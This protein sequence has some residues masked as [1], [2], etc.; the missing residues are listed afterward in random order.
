MLSLESMNE[1]LQALTL[2]VFSKLCR[3]H[4]IVIEDGDLTIILRILKNNPY[5]VFKESYAPIL[6]FE[7]MKETD[8]ETCDQFKPMIEERY[9]VHEFE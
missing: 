1:R 9:L 7:I 6:L 2:N 3:S 4:D 8:R 5:S